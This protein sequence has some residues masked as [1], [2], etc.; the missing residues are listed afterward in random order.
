VSTPSESVV[1]AAVLVPIFQRGGEWFVVYVQRAADVPVHQSQ[2]AFP[3]GIHRPANE[4]LE[5]TALREAEEEIGLSPSAV[6]V[7]AGLPEVRTFTSNFL[8]APFIGKIADGYPFKPDPREVARVLVVRVDDLRAPGVFREMEQRL[9][10]GELA[11]VSTYALGND[12]IWGATERITTELLSRL[13][14]GEGSS[15][16]TG[17]TT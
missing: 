6:E 10:S 7:L 14:K 16:P 17:F 3:G 4:T 15:G 11:V 1:R 9:H 12:V 8:I 2:I 13:S 5:M